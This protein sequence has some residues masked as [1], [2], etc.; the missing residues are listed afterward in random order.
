MSRWPVLYRV[1][2]VKLLSQYV[3]RGDFWV[4]TNGSS[5]CWWWGYQ[6]VICI[7]HWFEMGCHFSPS[8]I[9]LGWWREPWLLF[10]PYLHPKKR[11]GKPTATATGVQV[12]IPQRSRLDGSGRSW[13]CWGKCS[14][15]HY[16]VLFLGKKWTFWNKSIDS[17][18]CDR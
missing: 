14:S 12:A 8:L 2:I 1:R 7:Y 11:R 6:S 16:R 17:N 10:A 9:Q 3:V 13:S 5:S 4:P 15:F 18:S